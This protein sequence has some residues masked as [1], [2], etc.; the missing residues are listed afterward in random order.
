[1]KIE[2]ITLLIA[3]HLQSQYSSISRRIDAFIQTDRRKRN[4]APA[5]ASLLGHLPPTLRSVEYLISAQMGTLFVYPY[6]NSR[7][8]CYGPAQEKGGIGFWGELFL[9]GKCF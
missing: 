2:D 6:G 1:M 3:N 7:K 5:F 4:Q 9:G 8:D